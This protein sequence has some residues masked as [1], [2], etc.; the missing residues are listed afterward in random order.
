MKL[1]I[2]IAVGIVVVVALA[3]L[4][5]YRRLKGLAG[6]SETSTLVESFDAGLAIPMRDSDTRRPSKASK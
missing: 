4:Y 6:S 5:A 2:V 1:F 3:G